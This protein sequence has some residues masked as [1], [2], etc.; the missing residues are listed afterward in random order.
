MV[1]RAKIVEENGKVCEVRK[2]GRFQDRVLNYLKENK[3]NAYQQGEIAKVM[4]TSEQQARLTLMSLVKKNL[5]GRYEVP[6]EKE[7]ENEK[8]ETIKRTYFAVVYKYE[9]K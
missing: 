4:D 9:G 2:Y 1:V 6:T 5:V 3:S 7:Y 8:G